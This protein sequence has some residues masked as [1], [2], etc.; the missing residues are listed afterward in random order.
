MPTLNASPRAAAPPQNRDDTR[1]GGSRLRAWAGRAWLVAL[2]FLASPA[3]WS[4]AA[5]DTERL[6]ALLDAQ[7]TI[8]SATPATFLTP[9]RR[10][11]FRW[12]SATQPTEARYP[13]Y[14]NSPPF[15]FLGKK[16]V[17]AYVRFTDGTLASLYVSLYNRGD[18]GGVGE[19]AFTGLVA[20]IGKDLTEWSGDKGTE[21][22]KTRLAG[23]DTSRRIWVRDSYQATLTW[24]SSGKSKRDFRAEYV[25]VDMVRFDAKRDPRKG[26]AA[27]VTPKASDGMSADLTDHIIRKDNGDVYLEKVPMVDQGMKGYCAAA[28]AER[29][30]R[31]YGLDVTQHVIAQ[32]TDTDA[33]R[34]TSA[35]VMIRMLKRAATKFGVKIREHYR[36][37][38]DLR[39]LEE[40]VTRYNRYAKKGGGAKVVLPTMGVIDL[41]EIYASFSPDSFARYRC[42]GEKTDYRRF[43]ADVKTHI[44]RGIPLVWTVFLGLVSEETLLPQTRGAHMRLIIGYNPDTGQIIYSDSWGAG[45]E[46][47]K[48]SNDDAWTMTLGLY[49]Y[50]PR[51]QP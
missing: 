34:G 47:K 20:A 45:H 8:W 9:E 16:V 51:R 49:S 30:L 38:E 10:P 24:S 46:F 29:I 41:S 37:V 44:D 36:G 1:R 22:R 15:T 50:D 25:Q 19:E 27:S 35:E 14:A 42:D 26:T 21:P 5:G 17:E 43:M 48:L 23:N 4:A 31:Y 2:L 40:V 3:A 12:L 6:D 39:S 7:G 33:G 32:L 18:S 13:G 11:Y 28:T